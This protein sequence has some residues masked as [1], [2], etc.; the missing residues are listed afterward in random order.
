MVAS[1]RRAWVVAGALLALAAAAGPVGAQQILLDK[2]VKAGELTLFPDLNNE[3]IYYYVPDKV[4]VAKDENGTPQFS[5]LRYVE[6]VRS[7]ADQPEATEGLGGGIVHALVTLGVTPEQIAAANRELQRIKA[8]AKIQGPVVFKSGRFGLVSSFADPKGGLS[9][10]VVGLGNAPLLD[11]EK[12]AIS[13]ELTK[14]GAKI[15][16]QSFDTPTPD[17]SFRFEMDMTGYRSPKR[18]II[19][20][21]WSKVYSHRSFGAGIATSYLAAEIKDAFDELRTT[22]AIKIT[23]IGS[24]IGR[25]F[26]QR[27]RGRVIGSVS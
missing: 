27:D 25:R 12:A 11:G 5:F 26:D 18:A 7:G 9:K 8:G 22:D 15:L 14:Q 6:N 21:D 10:Q 17:I 4:R 13:M 24:P 2:P 3:S 19:D 20:A 16:W 23:Q 1:L